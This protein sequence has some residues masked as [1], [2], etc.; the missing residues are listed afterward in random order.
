MKILGMGNALV[1]IM[2]ELKDDSILQRFKFPKGSMTL[3]DN[4]MS[5][6]L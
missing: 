6:F 1:D 4:E 2:T 3:V 5:G